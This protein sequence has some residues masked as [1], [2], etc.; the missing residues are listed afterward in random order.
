ML[1]EFLGWYVVFGTLWAISILLGNWFAE[2]ED[3]A[4]DIQLILMCVAAV[5][6]WAPLIVFLVIGVVADKKKGP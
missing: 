5:P 2:E 3:R 6:F 1:I 4:S